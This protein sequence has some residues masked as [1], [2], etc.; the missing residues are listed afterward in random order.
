MGHL[1]VPKM[2]QYAEFEYQLIKQN[3][4]VACS[5]F[6]RLQ[7]TKHLKKRSD[8]EGCFTSYNIYSISFR[9]NSMPT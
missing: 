8:Q 7:T 4:I 3:N 9:I 5:N 1:I 2:S 6:H